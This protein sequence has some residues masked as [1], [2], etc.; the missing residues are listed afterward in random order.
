MAVAM[1]ERLGRVG[2]VGGGRLLRGGGL[3]EFG[4]VLAWWSLEGLVSGV[5]KVLV[6]DAS[7]DWGV[8]FVGDPRGV[9][10]VGRIVDEGEEGDSG[11]RKGEAGDSGRRNGDVRGEP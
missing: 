2:D 6:G 5:W 3:S 11:R 9:G 10:V 1:L 7:G 4:G 8:G